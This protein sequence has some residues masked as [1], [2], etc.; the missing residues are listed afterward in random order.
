[1]FCL[2]TGTPCW[3]SSC[4]WRPW[5][6][7]SPEG[8][9]SREGDA[10]ARREKVWQ[11]RGNMR[12]CLKRAMSWTS[13][14]AAMG[15]WDIFSEISIG[16]LVFCYEYV[17]LLPN[18]IPIMNWN[19]CYEIFSQDKLCMHD[20]YICCCRYNGVGQ[21]QQSMNRVA[22]SW[23]WIHAGTRLNTVCVLYCKHRGR[24]SC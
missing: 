22:W 13:S 6:E 16:Y 2:D 24:C 21:Y 18:W 20:I 3:H 15:S 23:H 17:L 4:L 5:Q 10:W 1:M 12:V 14:V 8:L 11:G 9:C 7:G 19:L